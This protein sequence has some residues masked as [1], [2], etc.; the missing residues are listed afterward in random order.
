MIFEVKVMDE[1]SE[2]MSGQKD[3]KM[4]IRVGLQGMPTFLK[5]VKKEESAW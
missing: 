4:Q 3:E 5:K 2:K 1:V